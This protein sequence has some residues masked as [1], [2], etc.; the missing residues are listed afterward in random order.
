MGIRLTTHLP[1]FTEIGFPPIFPTVCNWDFLPFSLSPGSLCFWKPKTIL[2]YFVNHAEV[3]ILNERCF[4]GFISVTLPFLSDNMER[5]LGSLLKSE[6]Y[7]LIAVFMTCFGKR[8][9]LASLR[10]QWSLTPVLLHMKTHCSSLITTIMV[11]FV[12]C[13]IMVQFCISEM[14]V[15][16]A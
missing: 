8:H 11:V 14:L 2:G 7:R 3:S 10:L 12:F 9:F 13:T 4:H 1:Q 16:E 5:L 6:W 15:G